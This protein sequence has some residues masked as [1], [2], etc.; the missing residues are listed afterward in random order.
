MYFF[1]VKIEEDIHCIILSMRNFFTN[2]LW[3]CV[4]TSGYY[5]IHSVCDW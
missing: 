2:V 1:G 4:P 3:Y 5:N